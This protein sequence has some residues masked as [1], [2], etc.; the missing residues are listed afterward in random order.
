MRQGKFS[1]L[2]HNSGPVATNE[3]EVVEPI[4]G[5]EVE[6]ESDS[7]EEEVGYGKKGKKKGKGKGKKKTKE[8]QYS[9]GGCDFATVEVWFREVIDLVR[10]RTL[11]SLLTAQLTEVSIFVSYSLEEKTTSQSF[12]ILSSSSLVPSEGT[13]RQSTRS[14]ERTSPLEKSRVCCWGEESI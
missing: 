12:L 1:E 8:D 5:M 6:E 3:G 14:T 4:E 7:S 13:T 2:I 11:A 10:T 9:K